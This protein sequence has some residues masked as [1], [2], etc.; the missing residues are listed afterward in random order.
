M[1]GEEEDRE[2]GVKTE[3]G[4]RKKGLGRG[5]EKS[6]E[7]GEKGGGRKTRRCEER[8]RTVERGDGGRSE[9]RGVE[10]KKTCKR[11]ETDGE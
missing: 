1:K 10:G 9:G 6:E 4:V 2:E 7:E 3:R 8:D 5:N 11:C